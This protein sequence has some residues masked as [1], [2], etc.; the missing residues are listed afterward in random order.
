MLTLSPFWTIKRLKNDYLLI[1]KNRARWIKLNKTGMDIINLCNGQ[2]SA[3]D[4]INILSSEYN[5]PIQNIREVVENYLKNCYTTGILLDTK[6]QNSINFIEYNE[7]NIPESLPPELRTIHLL[8]DSEKNINILQTKGNE[9]KKLVENIIEKLKEMCKN[10]V[11]I[12]I[13][14]EDCLLQPNILE[15]LALRKR[16]KRVSINLYTNGKINKKIAEKSFMDELVKKVDKISISV[17]KMILKTR[18]SNTIRVDRD[19]KKILQFIKSLRQTGFKNY[20]INFT[21]TAKGYKYITKILK[22]TLNVNAH[23]LNIKR[24]FSDIERPAIDIDRKNLELFKL[25]KKTVNNLITQ[26]GSLD[27]IFDLNLQ[28]IH[29]KELLLSRDIPKNCGLGTKQLCIILNGNVYPCAALCQSEFVLGNI[30]E[31]S[32]YEIRKDACDKYWF[33]WDKTMLGCKECNFFS[34]CDGGCRAAAYYSIGSIKGNDPRC[35]FL[36][37]LYEELISNLDYPLGSQNKILE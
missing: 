23:F 32:L 6:R 10:E 29:Y 30:Y 28:G 19:L 34:L 22:F 9:I 5:L 8:I 17:N 13:D 1:N 3:I 27:S 15:I 24:T 31:R 25:Y 33:L 14:W 36:Y 26:P 7:T 11:E 35:N 12:I 2:R 18:N 4:I 20:G 16:K 37:N 21:P